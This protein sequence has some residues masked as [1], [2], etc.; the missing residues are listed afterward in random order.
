MTETFMAAEALDTGHTTATNVMPALR[1]VVPAM[2]AVMPALAAVMPATEAGTIA[3]TAVV[4][5]VKV[6]DCSSYSHSKAPRVCLHACSA[7]EVTALT[8]AM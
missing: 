8:I 4:A 5:T 6:A 1:A 7:E 3:E 2:A